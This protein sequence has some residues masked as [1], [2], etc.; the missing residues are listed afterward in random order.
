MAIK[1]SYAVFDSISHKIKTVILAYLDKIIKITNQLSNWLSRPDKGSDYLLSICAKEIYISG[2]SPLQES[3][4][5]NLL[6]L[7]QSRIIW[8]G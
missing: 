8:L 2:L 6:L 1:L 7:K 4:H 3:V 5:D